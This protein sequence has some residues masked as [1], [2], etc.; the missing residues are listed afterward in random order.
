[1]I[2]VEF[3]EDADADLESILDYS[4][5]MFG[6]AIAEKYLR[7][8]ERALEELAQ[9]PE[10]GVVH[11]DLRQKPRC[12]PCREHRIFYRFDGAAVFVGR[13]LHKAMDPNKWL[14]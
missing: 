7:D 12:L 3:S 8:I 1:M 11:A 6:E 5:E 9:Y 10:L 2:P 4:V 14:L 13:I